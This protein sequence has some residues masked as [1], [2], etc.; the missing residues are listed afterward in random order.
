MKNFIVM[1]FSMLL[2]L[3]LVTQY[4]VE[5]KNHIIKIKSMNIVNKYKEIARGD[6][7]FTSTNRENMRNELKI[8]SGAKDSEI[9]IQVTETKVLR[10]NTFD[11]RGLIEYRIGIPIKKL[12][13]SN[14]FFNISD[15]DNSMIFW[16]SGKIGSEAR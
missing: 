4:G 9:H 8:I 14:K 10:T 5:N 3:S 12:I 6:G 15:E 11:Q 2:L 13:A 7:Y 16:I 1:V